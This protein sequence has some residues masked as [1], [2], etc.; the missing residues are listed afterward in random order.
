MKT[1]IDAAHWL[2]DVDA[3]LA[4]T[5]LT[6]TAGSDDTVVA[7]DFV[8]TQED[9]FVY[10]VAASTATDEHITTAGGVKLYVEA[11]DGVR[12]AKAFGAKG[13]GTTDDTAALEKAIASFPDGGTVVLPA[14]TYMHTG[15][16]F[17][18]LYYTTIKGVGNV[19]AYTGITPTGSRLVNT[20]NTSNH[21]EFIMCLG[22]TVQNILF[23][24]QGT[25]TAGTAV[26]FYANVGGSAA[27]Q[28][29]DCRFQD[30]F[31][32]IEFDGVAN[33]YILRNELER[34]VGDFCIKLQGTAK[35]MDQ[36]R[37]ED[38]IC[39][40]QI[41]GGSPV[42]DGIIVGT[43]T[44]TVFLRGNGVIKQKRGYV[45]DGAIAPAFTRF[46]ASEAERSN[47]SG[48]EIGNAEM[49]W[50]NDVYSSVNYGNGITFTGAFNNMAIVTNAD[51][52]GNYYHGILIDGS[53]GVDIQNARCTANG[54]AQTGWY[55]GL[56][57]GANVSDVTIMGGKFGGD[58]HGQGTGTQGWGILFSAGSGDK[59]IVQGVDATGNVTGGIVDGSTGTNKIITGNLV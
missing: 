16:S 34:L 51:V 22:V 20:S 7:G 14:G 17:T 40:S 52:R 23:E 59:F 57:T 58:I 28:V 55:H 33:S 19:A 8:R 42:T 47:Q 45:I 25:P 27:G 1:N 15:M 48:I 44:H 54:I 9:S 41:E 39:N 53:G 36:M 43:N 49:V 46:E 35:R 26:R 18:G 37:V 29:L 24:N 6:Y 13:D 11:Q 50:I 56:V 3:V 10:T 21:L 30:V 31:N 12:N 38:N 32:G 2:N 4:D 5:V